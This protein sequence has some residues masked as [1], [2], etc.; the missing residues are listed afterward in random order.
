MPRA[1]RISA[2]AKRFG[3]SGEWLLTGN[4]HMLP[5][6]ASADAV[7]EEGVDMLTPAER[8]LIENYRAA[9]DVGR[10][11]MRA[12]SAAIAAENTVT[13]RRR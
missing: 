8:A 12:A 2:I 10:R 13:R 4:G 7:K 9:N 11:T 3:V 1:S 5:G 6:S